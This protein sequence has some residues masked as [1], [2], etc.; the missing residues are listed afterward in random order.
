MYDYQ[1][2]QDGEKGES[3]EEFKEYG[4]METLGFGIGIGKSI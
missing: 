2:D 4:Y 1:C 3:I